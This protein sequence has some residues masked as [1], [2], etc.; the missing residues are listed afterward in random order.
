MKSYYVD[1]H[2]HIGRTEKGQ[3]VKISAA[4]DLTFFNIAKEATVRKGMEIIGIIDCHSP[5]VQDDIMTYLDRGEMVELEGGGIR[6]QDTTI[7][8]GCEIEVRDPGMGPAHL[9]AYMPNLKVMQGFTQW[10]KGHMKNVELSSQR[11]YVPA[12]ELQ[13]EVLGRGGILIPA[14]IFTPH[15]SVFGSAT[16]KMEYLLD[17]K[18]IS[19]VELG[20]SADSEMAGLISELDA[21][22][23]VTNSDAHSL[24]KI[25]REYNE[26]KLAAPTYE[27]LVKALHRQEERGLLANYGLNPRLGKYHRTY[28]SLCE[29]VLNEN[30]TTVERCADCGSNKIVKGVMDRIQH[31]ADRELPYLPPYRPPYHFQVPLEF[32]PGLGP[33][34]LDQ[35]LRRFGTEMNVLHRTTRDELASEVGEEIAAYIVKA[36]EGS[37][38][39]EVGGGGRYGKVKNRS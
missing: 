11:I 17:L 37:L 5:S 34:K 28:C 23:F 27:E 30:D 4:N 15:K 29:S 3:A 18:G 9:L 35:L 16:S 7:M 38:Q 26:M 10:M 21:F 36:R 20:L 6:Y 33:K 8:L 1:L 19:A 2:I 25:G 22:T 32:I 39:L 12:R 24:G 31:L 13:D 14:H